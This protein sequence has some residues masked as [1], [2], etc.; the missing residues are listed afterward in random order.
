[1]AGQIPDKGSALGRQSEAPFGQEA[2]HRFVADRLAG[3]EEG[4][5]EESKGTSL[6]P[7]D[8]LDGPDAVSKLEDQASPLGM[9][10][11]AAEESVPQQSPSNITPTSVLVY[12]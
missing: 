5:P 4:L 12:F 6:P 3:E 9:R 11:G 8:R 10:T 1:V 2:I 7:S